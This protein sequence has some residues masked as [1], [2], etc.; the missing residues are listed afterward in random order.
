VDY[1]LHTMLDT[2]P[3]QAIGQFSDEHHNDLICI[4]YRKHNI[5][6][7]LLKPSVSRKI[8][9]HMDKPILALKHI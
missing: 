8:I 6:D 3:F 7:S 4:M 5:L 9:S 2:D 1:K